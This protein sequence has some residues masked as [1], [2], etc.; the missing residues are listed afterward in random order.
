MILLNTAFRCLSC[1]HEWMDDLVSQAH[2]RIVIASMRAIHCPKCGVSIPVG[3]II[4]VPGGPDNSLPGAPPGYWGGVAPPVIDNTLPPPPPGIGPPPVGIWPPSP[5]PPDYPMPPG[6]IW[7]PVG[8]PSHPIAG[9]PP[10]RPDQGLPGS[11]PHPDQGLPGQPPRPDQGLPGAPP[12]PDHGLPSQKFLV[13]IVAVSAGGGL[14]VVGYTVVDPSLS[15]GLPLPGDQPLPGHD[16]PY[17]PARPDNT[18]PPS[19]QP[20]R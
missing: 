11:Q 19:A 5:L 9:T 18:L 7:P 12:R 2:F 15:V 1:K 10:P 20:R 13:A 6:S 16:L 8:H 14:R 4:V 3:S 17:P